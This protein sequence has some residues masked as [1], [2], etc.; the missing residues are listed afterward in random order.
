MDIMKIQL[1]WVC[2]VEYLGA[3]FYKSLSARYSNNPELSRVLDKFSKDEHR[4][5]IFFQKEYFEEYG[6]NIMGAPWAFTG[7]ALAISQILLP[8]KFKLWMLSA[9]ETLA[10]K[11]MDK[12]L[13]SETE[14]R[15]RKVLKKIKKDEED[16]AGFFYLMYPK[17]EA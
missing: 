11:I 15:Y 13:K 2:R 16:H 14:N 4:H 5:G 7:K 1:K 6:K 3:G 17:K 8:L 10:L 12:E 9:I